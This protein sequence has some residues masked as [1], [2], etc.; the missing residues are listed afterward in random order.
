MAQNRLLRVE[1]GCYGPKI[2]YLDKF[3]GGY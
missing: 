1:F 3:L 2:G